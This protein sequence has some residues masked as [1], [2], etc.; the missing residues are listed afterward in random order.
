MAHGGS[1]Y[2]MVMVLYNVA[3]AQAWKEN[4]QAGLDSNA[5]SACTGRHGTVE[6]T[7]IRNV[8]TGS[9]EHMVEVPCVDP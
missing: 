6:V 8:Y 9:H 3:M 7:G 1:V 4:G 5:Y 2:V